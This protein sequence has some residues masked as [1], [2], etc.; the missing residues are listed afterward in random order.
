MMERQ[1]RQL[2][3]SVAV[4]IPLCSRIGII[5]DFNGIPMYVIGSINPHIYR[6]PERRSVQNQDRVAPANLSAFLRLRNAH[7]R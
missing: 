1:K 5:P 2:R 7:V 6:D 4:S 3:C